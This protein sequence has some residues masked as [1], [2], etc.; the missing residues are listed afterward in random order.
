M[1]HLVPDDVV[2]HFKMWKVERVLELP[3]TVRPEGAGDF[4]L[5]CAA[6]WIV[7]QGGNR[8]FDP[9]EKSVWDAAYDELK[10]RIRSGLISVTGIRNGSPEKIGDHIF[11]SS[12]RVDLPFADAS[13]D[14]IVSDELY[15]SSYAYIDPEHWHDGFDDSLKSCNTVVWSKLTVPKSE[16]ANCWPFKNPIRTGKPGRPSG[17]HLIKEQHRKRIERGEIESS[18]GMEAK[19]L[20]YWYATQPALPPVHADRIENEIREA[21]RAAKATK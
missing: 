6:Q 2:D 8:I 13:F 5:Y 16:V 4:P 21:H 3:P 10:A 15:L 17:M 1:N 11:S 7:T 18:V 12:L 9:S 20:E 19:H 14:L